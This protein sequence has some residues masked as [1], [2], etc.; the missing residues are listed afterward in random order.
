MSETEDDT[1]GSLGAAGVT[2][3]Q[4]GESSDTSSKKK[5]VGAGSCRSSTS[6]GPSS[7]HHSPRRRTPQNQLWRRSSSR[8]QQGRAR[9]SHGRE[10]AV[11][12]S[13]RARLHHPQTHPGSAHSHGP[14]AHPGLHQA[15]HGVGRHRTGAQRAQAD[16]RGLR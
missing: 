15:Q 10:A 16:G 2:N 3:V 11:R 8:P 6:H 13:Q 14:H 1:E 7:A 9:R 12:H 5:R 4:A